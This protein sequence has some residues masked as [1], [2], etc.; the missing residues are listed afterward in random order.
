MLLVGLCW[1]RGTVFFEK[2][3]IH[4]MAKEPRFF[5][6]ELANKIMQAVGTFPNPTKL[7]FMRQLTFLPSFFAEKAYVF[8][9]VFAAEDITYSE[10]REFRQYIL[11]VACG[12]AKNK[13]PELNTIVGI[14][15]EPPRLCESLSEDFAVLDCSSW[16]EDQQKW[17]E[18]ANMPFG[19]F[20]KGQLVEMKWSEF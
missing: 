18:E 13:F 12:A 19:F 3:A 16:P 8:L 20:K 1:G 11:E 6:R 10:Y 17:H 14:A 15:M 4:E 7:G 9:Q 5:R 2:S